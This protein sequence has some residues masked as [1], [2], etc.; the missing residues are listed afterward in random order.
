MIRL[1]K[2]L[3][4]LPGHLKVGTNLLYVAMGAF[5]AAGFLAMS[6][7]LVFSIIATVVMAPFVY[8]ILQ[9]AEQVIYKDSIAERTEPL[10]IWW[11]AKLSVSIAIGSMIT[12]KPFVALFFII[13]GTLVMSLFIFRSYKTKRQ[14]NKC[15][16][17]I[18]VSGT[19]FVVY[20]L[21]VAVST[22]LG[23]RWFV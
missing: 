7:N 22:S 9:R 16:M 21:T 13:M 4:K 20:F 1:E 14:K 23:W 11:I 6:Q 8:L 3:R 10:K 15:A 5:I 12:S 17:T 18:L 2:E 19:L